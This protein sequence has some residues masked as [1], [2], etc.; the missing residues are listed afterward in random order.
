ML[1]KRME[2][3]RGHVLPKFYQNFMRTISFFT[4]FLLLFMLAGHVFA[5]AT[6]TSG[7]SG[8]VSGDDKQPIGFASIAL[9]NARDSSYVK[10]TL[11][12]D[13][14]AYELAIAHPGSYI[15]MATMVGYKKTYTG[16]MQL[17][18]NERKSGADLILAAD[19]HQL[20]E[21]AIV[22]S[23]PLIEQKIDKTVLN[24]ENSVLAAGNSAL[25][26]LEKAPG[27][28]ID[29][30]DRISL[31]G[32]QGVMVMIDGKPTYLSQTELANLLRS[33]DGNAIQSIEI[34]TNP[35][36]RYDA[37]GNSG[38]INIKLK[39]N[40]ANGT[41]GSLTLGAGYG[42]FYK[43]NGGITLNHRENK[44]N[45]FG[46]YNHGENKRFNNLN[47]DRI[48]GTEVPTYFNQ[49]SE[50]ERKNKN[51]NLKG[52][53]DY[54]IN[55]KHTVGFMVNGYFNGNNETNFNNTLIGSSSLS[56]DSS[57]LVLSNAENHYN[58]MSY[59]FNYKASM[60]TSG[61][62]LTADIDY[63]RFSARQN[64]DYDNFFYNQ[65]GG[66]RKP[67]SYFRN[68][69]PTSIDIKS[70]KVDYVHPFSKSFKL[71]A[72][73][74][75]SWVSTDNDYRFEIRNNSNWENDP[76]RSNHFVYD[77]N[78]NAAYL[79]VNKELGKTNIQVGLRAEQTNSKG[80]L[81]TSNDLV[82]RHYLDF[83]PTVFVR[84]SLSEAH[85]VGLSY[86]KRVDRPSYEDLNPFVFF[87]DEYTYN[88]GNSF[89]NPQYTNS[90]EVSYSF[91]KSY[92]ASLNYR[93]TNDAITEV[94]LPDTV[95]KALFQTYQNLA[96]QKQYSLN[97]TAPVKFSKW[98]T[99]NNNINVF[100]LGFKTP[101]LMGVPFESGKV[102]AQL[103]SNHSFN[104]NKTI[105][106]EVTGNYQ[107]PLEYGTLNIL[108]SQYSVDLGV[109]KSFAD[110]KAN[111]KL[112]A[113]DIFNT[114][115]QHISSLIPGVN[116]RIN[117]KHES[118]VFRLTLTYRLGNNEITPSRKR[119]SGAEEESS[120]IK[121]GN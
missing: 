103:Y 31:R 92:Q 79:N 98:W 2:I 25:E 21:V 4:V 7:I 76:L 65:I 121:S 68:F 99:S 77:E 71:E 90:F 51:N 6:L 89:L 33:T 75:S 40:R 56:T 32:K 66:D 43:A 91:K 104:I 61:K 86:S 105:I 15:V 10:G 16:T 39:K 67:A 94:L 46:S 57:V 97:I 20:K 70:A 35:S 108:K 102:A 111:I 28:T 58:N 101:N 47:I 84:Q 93:I 8:I 54:F 64:L 9:L 26:I 19:N 27:V 50:F 42:T 62:E 36:S 110:K 24:V 22:S 38:I 49:L 83:F 13:K 23:K 73:A 63:S 113:S 17:S 29:K 11:T 60:D 100:Y 115:S 72:G 45:V 48:S 95:K 120:R 5:Q 106:A 30:D 14:G 59:N 119:S 34:I 109:S 114:R 116:Y 69:A 74:K 96:K 53:I 41:N 118:Q 107:T 87:L 52:G 85:E 81:A 12:N 117:Q 55:D 18:A 1:K 44:V 80:F 78:I 37:A 3:L 88:K 82:K 112:S